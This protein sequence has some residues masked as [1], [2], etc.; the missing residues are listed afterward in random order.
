VFIGCP[1]G[2]LLTVPTEILWTLRN[3]REISYLLRNYQLMFDFLTAKLMFFFSG[4]RRRVDWS[5][6]TDI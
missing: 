1:V 6:L 5:V 3:I 2:S 4:L